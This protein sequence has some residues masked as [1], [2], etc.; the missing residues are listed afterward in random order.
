MK[1]LIIVLIL[2]IAFPS[3]SLAASIEQQR[4]LGTVQPEQ[5]GQQK[6][7]EQQTTQSDQEK[8]KQQKQQTTPSDK[9]E[10]ID[11]EIGSKKEKKLQVTLP[12]TLIN[13]LEKT[14]QIK[15]SE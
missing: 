11:Q 12:K 2:C 1:Q 4:L 10:K 13:Y 3:L 15:K 8:Q 6:Q 9:Q 5:Q 14:G 7:E